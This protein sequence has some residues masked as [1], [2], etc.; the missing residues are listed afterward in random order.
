MTDAWLGRAV[1]GE[2]TGFHPLG[3]PA[4][5]ITDGES[6]GIDTRARPDYP[7]VVAARED[8]LAKMR[9]FVAGVFDD[10]LSRPRLTGSGPGWPPPG[11]RT[12][13]ECLRVILDDEWAHHRFAIRDLDAIAAVDPSEG[14]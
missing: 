7:A 9:E 10:D 3:L 12:A 13:L 4:S 1:L 8:R 6:Y 11:T 2:D 5:F 14:P